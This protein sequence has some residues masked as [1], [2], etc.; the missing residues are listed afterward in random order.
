MQKR[1]AKGKNNGIAVS[2]T[3]VIRKGQEVHK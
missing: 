3:L 2:G 1:K